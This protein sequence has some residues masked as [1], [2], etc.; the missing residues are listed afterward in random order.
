MLSN[1]LQYLHAPFFSW[2][3]ALDARKCE[4]VLLRL[5]PRLASLEEVQLDGNLLL[6][7]HRGKTLLGFIER[8]VT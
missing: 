8:S 7:G 2:M 4:S 5:A 3:W 6:D 1:L